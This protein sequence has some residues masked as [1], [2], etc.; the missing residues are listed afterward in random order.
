MVE[1]S[2]VYMHPTYHGG[3]TLLPGICTPLLL[4]GTHLY[5]PLPPRLHAGQ[6]ARAGFTAVEH[7]LTELFVS[8]TGIYVTGVTAC[9]RIGVTNVNINV[10]KAPPCA[11]QAVL[12]PN[13]E[14]VA[15]QCCTLLSRK[16]GHVHIP[17]SRDEPQV[18]NTPSPQVQTSYFSHRLARIEHLRTV[19]LVA[20]PSERCPSQGLY[21]RGYNIPNIPVISEK[22]RE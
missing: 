8:V 16:S 4:P 14:H 3:D 22:Q 17:F 5:L 6:C 2:L 9:S 11:L 13:V 7:G 21:P 10:R 15:H 20:F 1:D 19:R 12:L 18:D